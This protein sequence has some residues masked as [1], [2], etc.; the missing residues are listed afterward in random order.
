MIYYITH[1]HPTQ[2]TRRAVSYRLRAWP[3]SPCAPCTGEG[4]GVAKP[5]VFATTGLPAP[6][7]AGGQVPPPFP[8]SLVSFAGGLA[9]WVCGGGHTS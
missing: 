3:T 8:L 6:R 1:K 7:P 2:E 9:G 5:R 4:G